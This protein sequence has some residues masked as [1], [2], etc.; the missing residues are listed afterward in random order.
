M[1]SDYSYHRIYMHAYIVTSLFVSIQKQV[2]FCAFFTQ[3]FQQ[4]KQHR[5]SLSRSTK[6]RVWSFGYHL[7]VPL[8]HSAEIRVIPYII[9]SFIAETVL[10]MMETNWG[11]PVL[12]F[13]LVMYFVCSRRKLWVVH[14]GWPLQ[15]VKLQQWNVTLWHVLFLQINQAR[16]LVNHLFCVP[17]THNTS[18]QPLIWTTGTNGIFVCQYSE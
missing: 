3:R 2:E 7:K 11:C 12:A 16:F 4:Q 10:C 8:I 6:R 9:R 17:T 13:L 18:S 15:M 5:L 1:N 14:Y